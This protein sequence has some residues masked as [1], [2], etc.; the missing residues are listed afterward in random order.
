MG[1]RSVWVAAASGL[2]VGCF[3]GCGGDA[4]RPPDGIGHGTAG[5]Q[6]GDST[7]GAGAGGAGAGGAGAG[8]TGGRRSPAAFIGPAA[9]FAPGSLCDRSGWCWYNT[10]PTGGAWLAV[11]G[12]GQRELWFGGDG[13][14]ALHFMDGRWQAVPSPMV[15]ESIWG[16]PSDDVWFTGFIPSPADIHTVEHAAIAHWDGTALTI[17]QTF[18]LEP[19]ME[20]WGSGGN[21]V[22]AV[23]FFN[24][25]HWDGTAWSTILDVGGGHSVSGSGPNDVWVGTD[26]GLWH[27]DGVSWTNIATLDN[28]QIGQLT[29]A[30]PNDVWVIAGP[31]GAAQAVEHFDG[32]TW[33]LAFQT[34]QPN[35][36]LADIHAIA[37]DDVWVVGSEF[38]SSGAGGYLNHFDGTSWTRSPDPAGFVVE[39]GHSPGLGVFGVG[40]DGVLVQLSATPTP[41][42]TDLRQGPIVRMNGTFGT[43]PTDMWAV[44]DAGTILHYDGQK[45]V[46]VP[47]GTM[48]DLRDVWGSGPADVWTVGVGGTVLRFDGSRFAPVPSATSVDLGAVFTARSGDAWIG[49]D[50]GT[51][52]HWDGASLSP[53]TLSGVAPGMS[54]RDIHGVGAGDV[55]LSGGRAPSDFGNTVPPFVSHFDGAAWSPV[56]VLVGDPQLAT[57]PLVRIWALGASDVWAVTDQFGTDGQSLGTWRFDG[58]GWTSSFQLSSATFMF[59]NGYNGSF[60]FGPNDRWKVLYSGIWQRSTM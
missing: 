31:G 59:P 48:A 10:L 9:A 29:V 25:H 39:V 2:L 52:L 21:D 40:F 54:I 28:A 37:P 1:N 16:A 53:V 60:V 6:P 24:V 27:F 5:M 4:H 20:V 45:V 26:L 57:A 11:G 17:N 46:A 7:G 12:V 42:F 56:Q 32:T 58:T 18:D 55:W 14:D 50:A 36:S 49:G 34:E 30:G 41:S 22:Y 47:A 43:S 3:A 38:L 51:L 15:I 44:G 13:A 19:V 33:T 23:D 35:P 8:G